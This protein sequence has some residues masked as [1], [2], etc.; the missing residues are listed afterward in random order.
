MY[1]FSSGFYPPKSAY[2]L[3]F[4]KLKPLSGGRLTA[5][6]AILVNKALSFR[7]VKEALQAQM[8]RLWTCC[9]KHAFHSWKNDLRPTHMFIRTH[10]DTSA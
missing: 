2:L 7:E 5:S 3:Q 4:S 10:S 1:I 9:E 8:L 6:V